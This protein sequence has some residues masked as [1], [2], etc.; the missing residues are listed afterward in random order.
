MHPTLLRL[1][2]VKFLKYV[3]RTDQNSVENFLKGYINV[4]SIFICLVKFWNFW[5]SLNRVLPKVSIQV[6]HKKL[7]LLF[8]DFFKFSKL[9]P[10]R[11]SKILNERGRLQHGKKFW[12]QQ[13]RTFRRNSRNFGSPWY[14]YQWY[15]IIIGLYAIGKSI[16]LS[17][18]HD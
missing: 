10:I 8:Y 4:F 15:R 5:N 6:D 18:V 12:N 3:S 9:S 7:R 11:H 14:W 17:R 13:S 16:I 2:L 1:M